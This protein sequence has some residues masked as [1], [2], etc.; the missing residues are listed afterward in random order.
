M[1]SIHGGY[2]KCIQT[3]GWKAWVTETTG[4]GVLAGFIWLKTGIGGG[5]L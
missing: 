4:V 2:E 1:T 3:S 5:L